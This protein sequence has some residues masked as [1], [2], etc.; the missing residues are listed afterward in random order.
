M[1]M[2]NKTYDTL[3]RAHRVILTLVELLGI[4]TVVV[5]ALNDQNIIVP[6]IV[7]SIIAVCQAVLGYLLH[8]SSKEY[9]AKI[10][11]EATNE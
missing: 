4:A 1:T 8:I 5:Q 10:E 9:W 6:G 3:N 2:S 7:T 11:S